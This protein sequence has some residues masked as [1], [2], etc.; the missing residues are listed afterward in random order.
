[1]SVLKDIL[2]QIKNWCRSK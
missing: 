2:C 1:M